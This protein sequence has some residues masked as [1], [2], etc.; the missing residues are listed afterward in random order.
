M[1]GFIVQLKGNLTKQRY[2]YTT[3]FVDQYSHLS[4]V[5][6]Q[7]TISSDEMVQAKIAS[8]D[9]QK[10]EECPFFITMLTMDNLPTTVSLSIV[11]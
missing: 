6:L 2:I 9:I 3:I 10:N 11:N 5:F 1:P 4:Y 7:Q 8:N